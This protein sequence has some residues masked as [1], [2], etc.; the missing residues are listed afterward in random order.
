MIE[1]ALVISL[2]RNCQ[3]TTFFLSTTAAP[4]N[5]IYLLFTALINPHS[6]MVLFTYLYAL[7]G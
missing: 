7:W 5:Y 6:L 2:D 4:V 3:T 1:E